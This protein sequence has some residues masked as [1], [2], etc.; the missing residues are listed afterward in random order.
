M[1]DNIYD[2]YIFDIC[3]YLFHNV[4]KNKAMRT[5]G[6]KIFKSNDDIYAY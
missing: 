5:K 3:I 6:R 2:K 1:E 4:K